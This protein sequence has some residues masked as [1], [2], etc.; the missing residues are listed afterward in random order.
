MKASVLPG[1]F[2]DPLAGFRFWGSSQ[3]GY[4]FPV[5]PR[6]RPLLYNVALLWNVAIGLPVALAPV[7]AVTL[8][9]LTAPTG[10]LAEYNGRFLGCAMVI[11]G[12]FY[13]EIGR[14]LTTS[15]RFLRLA[16]VAKLVAAVLGLGMASI[17]SEL[18]PLVGGAIPVD[19]VF[20]AL[21][22]RDLRRTATPPIVPSSIS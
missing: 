9:G 2:R 1:L 8:M 20:A 13:F 14:D 11:F 18:W 22:V 21:F 5:P 4:L 6:P 7:Q 17:H 3:F 19:L 10:A 16:I 15:R 12:F